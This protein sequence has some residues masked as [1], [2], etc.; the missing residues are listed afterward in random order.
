MA[1]ASKIVKSND[2]RFLASVHPVGGLD[3]LGRTSLAWGTL[4]DTGLALISTGDGRDLTGDLRLLAGPAEPDSASL[5]E[6][7]LEPRQWW[8]GPDGHVHQ[9]ALVHL[10][11]WDHLGI[12]VWKPG[13]DERL[14]PEAQAQ[15][16]RVLARCR[17]P[18]ADWYEHAAKARAGFGPAPRPYPFTFGR[19]PGSPGHGFSTGHDAKTTWGR[20]VGRWLGLGG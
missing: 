16:D 6:A 2:S 20:L 5:L 19:L 14:D 13:T 1:M 4:I 17:P 7:P 3:D 11:D 10:S 8:K 9:V 12:D 15:A 18:L